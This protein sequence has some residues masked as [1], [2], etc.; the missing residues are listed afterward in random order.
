MLVSQDRDSATFVDR[1]ATLGEVALA[2]EITDKDYRPVGTIDVLCEEFRL[3]WPDYKD[4]P[5]PPSPAADEVGGEKGPEAARAA[6]DAE[7][8]SLDSA[9][10]DYRAK[11]A[12]C[13]PAALCLSGGGIRS[14][15]FA[16]GAME[17]LSEARLLDGFH[18]LS[19]V[20][21]G[22][23]I[24]SWLQRWIYAE[25]GNVA[26]VMDALGDTPEPVQVKHL[27]ENSNFL[28]PRVGIGSNDTWAA[29]AICIRN[30]LLNWLLFG[31]MLM[32]AALV[33]PA[34]VA[35]LV[36][37][38]VSA[39][40]AAA[41]VVLASLYAGWSLARGLPSYRPDRLVGSGSG[42]GWLFR[43]ILLPLILWA[44]AGTCLL[45]LEPPFWPSWSTG[46]ILAM[47][48]ML[49]TATGLAASGLTAGKGKWLAFVR[50][51]PIWIVSLLAVGAL[52]RLGA[53]LLD[54]YKPAAEFH[55][56]LG[57][58][59]PHN[60]HC[61]RTGA[62]V[63]AAPAWL[64]ACHFG[65]SILFV[66]L[67]WNGP[68]AKA[69]ADREWLARVSAIKVKPIFIWLF[70]AGCGLI[71]NWL[72]ADWW[73]RQDMTLTGL[74]ALVTG[75][76]A[77]GGGKSGK[78]GGMAADAGKKILKHLNFGTA[79]GLATLLFLA[80]LFVLL[81]RLDEHLITLFARRGV[82]WL[83]AQPLAWIDG[84]LAGRALGS[85]PGWAH[86]ATWNSAALYSALGIVLLL[87]L[88]WFSRSIQVNR[89][90]LNGLYRNRLDRG[91]LGAARENRIAD[92][93]TG[94]NSDDNIRMSWMI[95]GNEPDEH[96][97][98][99]DMSRFPF[100]L[101]P[102]V[103]VTLNA[104]ETENLAWQE[105]K[106]ESF[107]F[108]PLYSGGASL[109]P[110]P[111]QGWAP[112]ARLMTARSDPD[113]HGAYIS[114]KIYGG[115][116]PDFRLAGSGVSLASAM[117][118]SGAA[119]S[120]N[121]GYH[122]SAATAFLMTLFN[123]RL[124]AWLPNP[125]R[126]ADLGEKVGS[127][128]PSNSLR[129]LLS[130][131][132]GLTSDEA[133]DIYLSDG[134]HFENLAVYEMLR[135]RCRYI[136]V[137]D[138]G[139]DPECTF[140]DLGA[141]VRKAK[142]DFDTVIDFPELRLGSRDKPYQPEKDQRAWAFGTILYPE[143]TTGQ[144]LYLKPSFFGKDL[145]ADIRP[146]AT[147]AKPSRTRRPAI[148]SS[149]NPSSRAT[150]ISAISSWRSWPKAQPTLPACSRAPRPRNRPPRRR[151]RHR[152]PVRRGNRARPPPRGRPAP[153]AAGRPR[154]SFRIGRSRFGAARRPNR[155]RGG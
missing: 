97:P 155:G 67:R 62:I 81:G 38:V 32:L 59:G 149:P 90:S 55:C 27:R 16:L 43:H 114:S 3:I 63:F 83:E 103:N 24:G 69:D 87:L 89:F 84:R 141:L 39:K 123:V 131:M 124:G 58:T 105:R 44:A 13:A 113:A 42:D 152:V 77:V 102:I 104:T 12:D 14:A 121:M 138:A 110:V 94:F 125:V 75:W 18:Y 99:G 7:R 117:S 127:S 129:A 118:I 79:I 143:G 23:Y 26:K 6:A 35:V 4:P 140:F 101:Y 95:P 126:A 64:L 31:P 109:D 36:S 112:A 92:P 145:P 1:A 17:A 51:V 136:L 122:S 74:V 150:G 57:A 72:V 73:A 61:W 9:L 54:V 106:A 98:E 93:F 19:T 47:V 144:I 20:S 34:F 48:T 33:P 30:V 65:G 11:A 137:T 21:G 60:D 66:G 148:S 130:E 154:R 119:A 50:D 40:A 146:M 115:N 70:A 85:L 132:A 76:F 82:P 5:L 80:A 29:V 128:N 28:T 49:A 52:I 53:S 133:R 46:S 134:G 15:S 142:I 86:P 96:K 41:A 108:T 116:E 111:R 147:R 88:W 91:F 68:R 25:G 45:T 2:F 8:K 56:A 37:A 139:A 100:R 151:R 153:R 22:G 120:P 10:S 135:R 71:L 78:S 107:V